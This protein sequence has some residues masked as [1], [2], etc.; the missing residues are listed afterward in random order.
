M[1]RFL[2]VVAAGMVVVA[3]SWGLSIV[4][5]PSQA[6]AEKADAERARDLQ[7]LRSYLE[8]RPGEPVLPQSL[9]DT[10]YCPGRRGGLTLTDP[11][12]GDGYVYKRLSDERFEIC[13]QFEV[14]E[15][16]RQ[17]GARWVQL[18]FDGQ[19]GCLAGQRRL[20]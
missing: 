15:H 8:C 19:V 2:F 10:D 12:T 14:E 17:D 7:K 20:S 9:S 6:R 18:V 16:R 11:V 4:G 3:L 5:G 13:A 1:N